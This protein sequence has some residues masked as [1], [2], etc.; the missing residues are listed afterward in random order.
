MFRFDSKK[1]KCEELEV[2]NLAKTL[3][4]K[5]KDFSTPFYVYSQ[6]QLEIN[7]NLYKE[8]SFK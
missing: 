6:K 4:E 5:F 3:K 1:L 7:V 2:K 8:V